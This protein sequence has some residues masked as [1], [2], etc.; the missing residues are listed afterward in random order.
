MYWVAV[1]SRF[2]IRYTLENKLILYYYFYN[3]I[4]WYFGTL[5]SDYNPLKYLVP[6]HCVF[7][8]LEYFIM[9][10]DN[11]AKEAKVKDLH[12]LKD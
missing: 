1:I 9:W 2:N 3:N 4:I 5:K 11:V 10:Q 12:Y 7:A 6:R 8:D